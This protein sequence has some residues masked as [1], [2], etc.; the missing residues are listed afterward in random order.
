MYAFNAPSI[1]HKMEN[2]FNYVTTCVSELIAHT[3]KTMIISISGHTCIHYN[4]MHC[5]THILAT[6]KSRILASRNVYKGGDPA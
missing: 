3:Y 2:Y 6:L 1:A 5:L 4:I